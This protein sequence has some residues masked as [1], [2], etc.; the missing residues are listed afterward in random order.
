M[1][2]YGIYI[3]WNVMFSQP[4]NMC[5]ILK[6]NKITREKLATEPRQSP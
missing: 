2:E 4:L 6:F 5:E 1:A 3:Y